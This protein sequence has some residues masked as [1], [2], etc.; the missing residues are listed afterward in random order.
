ML[1]SLNLVQREKTGQAWVEHYSLHH[2]DEIERFKHGLSFSLMAYQALM[3]R[4]LQEPALLELFPTT[5]RTGVV[6]SDLVIGRWS[7]VVGYFLGFRLNGRGPNAQEG[8]NIKCRHEL[9]NLARGRS[10]HLAEEAQTVFLVLDQGIALAV[11]AQVHAIA[12]VLHHFQVV[13]PEEINGLENDSP[14][15]IDHLPIIKRYL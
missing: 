14:Q 12:Q 11:G 13:H 15:N 3:F 10:L 2:L 9:C 6:S 8:L 4:G 5:A 7:L 1:E